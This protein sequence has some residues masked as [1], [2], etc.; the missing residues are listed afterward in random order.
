M[1]WRLVCVTFCNV[2]VP[3]NYVLYTCTCDE[4]SGDFVYCVFQ[5]GTAMFSLFL[6][7][8]WL[9]RVVRVVRDTCDLSHLAVVYGY[10]Q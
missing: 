3:V 1:V 9:Y 8:L 2:L 10:Y 6:S 5:Y 4:V 7:L